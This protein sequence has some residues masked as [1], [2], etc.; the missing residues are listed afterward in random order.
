M[1][2]IQAFQTEDGKIFT[3][4]DDAEEHEA[5]LNFREQIED[6]VDRYRLNSLSCNGIADAIYNNHYEL[7][8]ILERINGDRGPDA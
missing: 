1:K 5:M 8:V 3:S 4:K 7:Y 6:Y 2:E